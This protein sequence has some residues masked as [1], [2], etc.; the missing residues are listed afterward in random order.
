MKPKIFIGSS[1]ESIEIAEAFR[2]SLDYYAEVTVWGDSLFRPG[3]YTLDA[4]PYY[5]VSMNLILR[6]LF[7]KLMML[8]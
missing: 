5:L 8:R 7:L 1:S 6:F 4:L 3:D 2:E